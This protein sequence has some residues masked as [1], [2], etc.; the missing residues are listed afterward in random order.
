MVSSQ[1]HDCPSGVVLVE[2]GKISDCA[3][4]YGREFLKS[5]STD[6]LSLLSIIIAMYYILELNFPKPYLQAMGALTSLV[7]GDDYYKLGIR[8]TKMLRFFM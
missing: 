8:A 3:A 1:V 5:P 4:V 2:G 6:M 7:L